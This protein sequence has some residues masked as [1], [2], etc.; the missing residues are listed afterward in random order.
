MGQFPLPRCDT[1]TKRT[2]NSDWSRPCCSHSMSIEVLG[3][4]AILARADQGIV[5]G[6][7]GYHTLAQT[8]PGPARAA[9]LSRRH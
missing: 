9:S 1:C 8:V 6:H 2:A 5:S 3:L 7:I 4:V